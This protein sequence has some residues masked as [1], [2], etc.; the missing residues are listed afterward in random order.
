[1][2]ENVEHGSFGT[3]TSTPSSSSRG[4]GPAQSQE[5]EIEALKAAVDSTTPLATADS[6]RRSTTR[7]SSP[8]RRRSSATCTGSTSSGKV[9]STPSLRAGPS[10]GEGLGALLAAA[11][12]LSQ[13]FARRCGT[14][15]EPSGS[16]PSGRSSRATWMQIGDAEA[17]RAEADPLGTGGLARN[18]VPD[19][20]LP[21][22]GH[23]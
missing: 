2:R 12:P 1:M 21:A 4:Y 20:A 7:R 11:L 5:E 14:G 23:R 22:D 15:H 13:D 3:R 6:S 8:R 10:P 18:G 19:S 9:S 16:G 17:V